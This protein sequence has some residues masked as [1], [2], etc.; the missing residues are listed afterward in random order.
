MR[1]SDGTAA[2]KRDERAFTPPLGTGDTDDYDR[3]IRRWTAPA[4][5]DALKR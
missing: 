4:R 5:R 3:T 1:T 2:G